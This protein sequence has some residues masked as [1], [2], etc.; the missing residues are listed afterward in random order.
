[1]GMGS[2]PRQQVEEGSIMLERQTM[3][4]LPDLT[5]MQVKTTVHESKVDMLQ[6]GMRA[7]IHIQDRDYQGT[8]T[9]IASQPEPSDFY[10]GNVK[11][12]A[13]LVSIDSD[14]TGLRPG[15][16]AAVEI[17]V[18]NRTGALS[19]PVECVVEQGGKFYCWIDT[20]KGPERR[21]LLLGMSNNTR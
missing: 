14:P 12:Y 8:V 16:T 21:L 18:A 4:K 20:F 17:L 6:R 15:M 5:R 11:E 1:R 7:R 3:I 19:V 2:S 13:T 9:S 10:S